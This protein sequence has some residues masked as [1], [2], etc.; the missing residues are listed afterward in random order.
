MVSSLNQDGQ[1]KFK[2]PEKEGFWIARISDDHE[3]FLKVDH[4]ES[5]PAFLDIENGLPFEFVLQAVECYFD[6]F[7]EVLG[8]DFLRFQDQPSFNLAPFWLEDCRNVWSNKLT[9]QMAQIA[10]AICDTEQPFLESVQLLFWKLVHK[11]GVLVCF[12]LIRVP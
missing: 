4:S 3:L 1:V 8:L 9:H 7:L 2:L 10:M 6:N 11:E 12:Y 5:A